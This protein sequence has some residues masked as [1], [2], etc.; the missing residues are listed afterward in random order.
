MCAKEPVSDS[1]QLDTR[2]DVDMKMGKN[3]VQYVQNF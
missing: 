3:F 2:D 1:K